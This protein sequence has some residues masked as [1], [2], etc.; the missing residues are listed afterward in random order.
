MGSNW[1]FGG[2]N[3]G[4]AMQAGTQIF[5]KM[6]QEQQQKQA[7]T[8][9][10]Q[11]FD[12]LSSLQKAEEKRNKITFQQQQDDIKKKE[13]YF[14][15]MGQLLEGL[16]DEEGN[17]KKDV[18]QK[19]MALQA[20]YTGQVNKGFL[21]FLQP[22]KT[23]VVGNRIMQGIKVVGELPKTQRELDKEAQEKEEKAKKEYNQKLKERIKANTNLLKEKGEYDKWS[24]RKI[25]DE[26]VKQLGEEAFREKRGYLP[27]RGKGS[28][29]PQGLF[30]NIGAFIKGPWAQW[31]AIPGI[32]KEQKE[33]MDYL[34]NDPKNKGKYTL[35]EARSLAAQIK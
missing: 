35:D 5:Q 2:M 15:K 17:I 7:M 34:L 14:A 21:D 26:A 20:A 25:E 27:I 33:F 24:A 18:A 30:G 3:S 32:N 28:T 9:E 23:K 1:L 31:G 4:Q 22:E 19:V 16:F 13:Q 10:K 12:L 6:A 29:E 11:K 8:F